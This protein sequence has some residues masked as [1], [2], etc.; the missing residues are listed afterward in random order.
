MN[1]GEVRDVWLN[2]HREQG[3]VECVSVNKALILILLW[4]RKHCWREGGKEVRPGR[5][6]EELSNVIFS[7]VHSHANHDS[8][9]VDAC[10]EFEKQW[11]LSFK[12]EI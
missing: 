1:Y 3:T 5:L 11:V 10:T 4:L 7:M 2:R 8:Q 9:T 6:E 12:I